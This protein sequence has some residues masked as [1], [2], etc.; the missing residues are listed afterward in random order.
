MRFCFEWRVRD[1]LRL[2][3]DDAAGPIE[4]QHGRAGADEDCVC[5]AAEH[6]CE[7]GAGAERAAAASDASV[8]ERSGN[9]A[10]GWSPLSR[11]V[12]LVSRDSVFL[13]Q[14]DSLRVL[15]Q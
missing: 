2:S 8:R 10:A 3:G 14:M 4:P 12:G 5:T 7:R 9:N 13:Q 1:S 11:A 15:S 6:A